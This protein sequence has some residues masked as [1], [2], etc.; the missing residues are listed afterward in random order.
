MYGNVLG[1]AIWFAGQ[2]FGSAHTVEELVR[3]LRRRPVT[4]SDIFDL[5]IEEKTRNGI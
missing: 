5:Q 2:I 4:G 1:I 3:L